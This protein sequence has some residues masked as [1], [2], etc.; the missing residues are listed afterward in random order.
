MK[1]TKNSEVLLGSFRGCS[2]FGDVLNDVILR[3]FGCK[4]QHSPYNECNFLAIGSV[5]DNVVSDSNDRKSG[6]ISVW[7]SGFIKRREGREFFNKRVTIFALRGIFSKMRCENILGTRLSNM[8]LGDPGLLISRIYDFKNEQKKYDVGIIPHY[9]DKD[10]NYLKKIP[11]KNKTYLVIDILE[12]PE[13]VCKKINQCRVIIS[14]AMHGLVAADSYG[15]PNQ[16]IRLSDNVVGGEYKFNDYYSAFDLYG[17]RPIDLRNHTISDDDIDSIVKDYE[18]SLEK[19]EK[20]CDS[21]IDVFPFGEKIEKKREESVN[22]KSTKEPKISI[23]VPCYNHEQYLSETLQSVLDQ[24]YQNWECIIVDD[25]SSDNTR[26]V[27]LNFCKRSLKF[28]YFYQDNSGPA[29]ARNVGIAKSCG[30]YILPLDGDDRISADYLSEAVSVF[31]ENEDVKLIYC[32]AEFFGANSGEWILPEYSYKNMLCANMIFCTGLFSR[33]DFD[34]TKG[35]DEEM[36]DGLED[37]DFW[38]SFLDQSSLVYRLPKIHFYYRIRKGSR[39]EMCHTNQ[40]I[41]KKILLRVYKNHEEKY[42]EI[43][44]P[45][46]QFQKVN[47]LEKKVEYLQKEI[48]QKDLKLKLQLGDKLQKK[49]DYIKY[50]Q[51][52]KFWKLRDNYLKF[53]F[54]IFSPIKFI[55]KYFF[56]TKK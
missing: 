47:E 37:W 50:I 2:N 18:I 24:E 31:L 21:L 3:S 11:L 30:E 38:L 36:K 10:I 45:L 56:K 20:I 5:L 48:E 25:G 46:I 19:V 8:P 55:N 1:D 39:N 53:R 29:K 7:G 40:H 22:A 44:N 33:K 41:L 34:R 4:Y 17:K 28:H 12:D 26:N 23:I 42:L 43:I 27:C 51:S 13:I 54:V 9:I 14:S 16:W 32:R 15:I 49:D 52:S 6:T 35:Y